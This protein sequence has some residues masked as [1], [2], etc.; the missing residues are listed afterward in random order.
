[1]PQRAVLEIKIMQLRIN[2]TPGLDFLGAK[3]MNF[4][5]IF[6]NANLP[7]N[8]YTHTNIKLL[9]VSAFIL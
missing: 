7:P 5:A 3:H 8:L 1:M 6:T 4:V 9:S 2:M